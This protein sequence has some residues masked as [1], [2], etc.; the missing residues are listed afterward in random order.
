MIEPRRANDCAVSAVVLTL[1]E[2]RRIE[3]AVMSVAWCDE[4]VVVDGGSRDGTLAILGR[5]RGRGVPLRVVQRAWPDSFG[6]QKRFAVEQARGPWILSID[7][8]E[9]VDSQ[10]RDS[11]RAVVTDPPP[12]VDVFSVV[13]RNR[14]M[15]VVLTTSGQREDRP[16]RLFRKGAANFTDDRVHEHIE[17]A[18]IVGRLDGVLEHHSD[19]SVVARIDRVNRYSSLVARQLH[20]RGEELPAVRIVLG[21]LRTFLRN[22]VVLRGVRQGVPGFLWCA[23]MSAEDF[24]GRA[25]LWRLQRAGRPRAHG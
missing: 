21:P 13:R 17:H 24:L 12:S 3:R 20:E 22:Y 8:D 18:G 9:V 5:L 1:D 16:L 19:Q 14:F 2:E 11:I 7:A 4:I 10:L 6:A 25:K 15:G 23:A